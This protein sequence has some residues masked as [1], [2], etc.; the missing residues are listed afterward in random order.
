[1]GKEEAGV[2]GSGVVTSQGVQ[3][4][5]E[6]EG[7]EGEEGEEGDKRKTENGKVKEKKIKIHFSKCKECGEEFIMKFQADLHQC[8]VKDNQYRKPS[9]ETRPIVEA[10]DEEATE[11]N[12]EE[13]EE[14]EEER[15]NKNK[16]KEKEDDDE[17]EEEKKKE[18]AAGAGAMSASAALPQQPPAEGGEEEDDLCDVCFNGDVEEGDEIV[19]CSGC[20]ICVHQSC[21]GIKE[22]PEGDWYCDG[23]LYK[24]KYPKRADKVVCKLCPSRT[25]VLKRTEDGMWGHAACCVW[26]PEIQFDDEEKKK[27]ITGLEALNPIR[28]QLVSHLGVMLFLLQTA[29]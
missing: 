16:K 6:K 24:R 3:E 4:A 23:C 21:Y 22:V 7:E 8:L 13:E 11:E 1:M 15:K 25:G 9:R 27:K 18:A 28:F 2:G 12:E 17:E 26:I 19:F 20:D 5:K 14:E 29:S 10:G